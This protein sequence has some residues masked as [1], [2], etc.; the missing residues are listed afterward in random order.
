MTVL[1]ITVEDEQVALL[2]ELLKQV[3]FVKNIE[4]DH[5]PDAIS[6]SKTNPAYNKVKKLLDDA[7]GKNLFKNIDD[8]SEWQRELRKEWDRDF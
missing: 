6:S 2:R 1:K 4:E 8:P 3:S 5:S 7:K